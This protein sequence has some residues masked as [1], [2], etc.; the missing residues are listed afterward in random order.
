MTHCQPL[1]P[2]GIF[3]TGRKGVRTQETRP[4]EPPIRIRVTKCLA[5]P[6]WKK[7]SNSSEGRFEA[8]ETI[9]G[10]GIFIIF[11]NPKA[12]FRENVS[13]I[14]KNVVHLKRG[15]PASVRADF[16]AESVHVILSR[17]T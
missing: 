4:R 7:A 12:F 1:C 16:P 17:K 6:A 9:G 14:P 13:R 11:S 3:L 15:M 8:R 10:M 2:S 5:W